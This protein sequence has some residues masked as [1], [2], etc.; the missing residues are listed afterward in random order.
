M[1]LEYKVVKTAKLPRSARVETTTGYNSLPIHPFEVFFL[2]LGNCPYLALFL[3]VFL[4]RFCNVRRS[5]QLFL[6]D[7]RDGQFDVRGRTESSE[8]WSKY[9]A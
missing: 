7:L 6:R 5:G 8:A 3:T 4:L 1:A 2:E 9:S